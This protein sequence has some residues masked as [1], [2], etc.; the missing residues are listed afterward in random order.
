MLTPLSPT[1]VII[2]S[3]STGG[4]CG[5]SASQKRLATGLSRTWLHSFFFIFVLF[6]AGLPA[7]FYSHFT[8]GRHGPLRDFVRDMSESFE[9]KVAQRE[10]ELRTPDCRLRRYARHIRP[11]TGGGLGALRPDCAYRDVRP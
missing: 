9:R 1:L 10:T 2:H 6:M 5:P 7:R 4:S 8:S 11:A 3:S